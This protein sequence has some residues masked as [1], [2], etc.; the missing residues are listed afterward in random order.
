MMH[1]RINWTLDLTDTANQKL[2]KS[3]WNYLMLMLEG[4]ALSKLDIIT[5]KNAYEAW[6]HL[7]TKYEP[8]DDKAYADL[9]MKFAQCELDSPKENPEKWINE[10]IQINNRIANCHST[11][12]KSDVMM[13]AHVLSKLPKEEKYYK[14]FIAMTRRFGYSKQT[15][16]E[17]KKEVY[18]YW[19][20]NIK[21]EEEDQEA[22]E[23]YATYERAG[24][25]AKKL[26]KKPEAKGEETKQYFQNSG[27]KDQPQ[28]M[29]QVIW[30][31]TGPMVVP[32]G[33]MGQGHGS[34][35]IKDS[36]SELVIM[37]SRPTKVARWNSSN[38]WEQA[39]CV[40]ANG[41]ATGNDEGKSGE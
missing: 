39:I 1:W 25:G 16:L 10:L 22:D 5:S 4:E 11:Q 26:G 9:E 15:I 14:N 36:M 34:T 40:C 27:N 17:F 32:M 18:D 30:T 31:Q 38:K 7:K 3:A 12:K 13:I 19:E 24:N 20:N 28:V 29:G 41:N 2:S 23:A 6:E 21:Q 35:I 33:M 8:K 37:E